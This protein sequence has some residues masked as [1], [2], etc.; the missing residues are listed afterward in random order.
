MTATPTNVKATPTTSG[1]MISW[2]VLSTEG[3]Q[4]FRVNWRPKAVPVLPWH[5]ADLPASARSYSI[6]GL[7]AESIEGNVESFVHG[8]TVNWVTTPLPAPVPPA[9]KQGMIVGVNGGSLLGVQEA[10]R[11][12]GMGI[13]SERLEFYPGAT[14]YSG[15]TLAQ[16]KANGFKNQAVIIG[17]IPND[18]LLRQAEPGPWV[19]HTLIQLEQLQGQGVAVAEI[20][21][22]PQFKGEQPGGVKD[23]ATYAT[24]CAQLLSAALMR[25]LTDVP[26]GVTLFGS[27]QEP[28]GK[29]VQFN[30]LT[31]M[32][33]A[34]PGLP[35]LLTEAKG[36]LVHHTYGKAGESI[37]QNL[38]TGALGETHAKAVSLGFPSDVYCTELG[39]QI[40][41]P[42][43][44]KTVATAQQ[45]G[46]AI[47]EVLAK[48][49]AF[50]YVKGA[51]PYAMRDGAWSLQPSALAA[52]ASFA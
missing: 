7:P 47:Q 27:F 12:V 30:W 21:N 10:H 37:E 41:S 43:N 51:W 42:A 20:M 3:L 29:W 1:A 4:A 33:K 32:V 35:K 8:A 24:L 28:N 13:G 25:G 44:Y 48:L 34:Q 2:T 45:Q 49:K 40:G 46:T 14:T 52:I 6:A 19:A 16:S 9:P 38:G 17:N 31:D 36:A 18:M 23:P 26:L 15:T 50:G 11:L 5:S 39:F 22:E